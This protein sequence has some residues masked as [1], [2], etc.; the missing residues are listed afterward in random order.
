MAEFVQ[1]AR[2]WNDRH[3]MLEARRHSKHL[4]SHIMVALLSC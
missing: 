3:V 2:T 1:C 4:S